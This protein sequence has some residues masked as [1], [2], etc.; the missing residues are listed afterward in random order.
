MRQIFTFKSA[1]QAPVDVGDGQFWKKKQT[2]KLCLF[3]IRTGYFSPG[4]TAGSPYI[5]TVNTEFPHILSPVLKLK[6][7]FLREWF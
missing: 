3:K 1:T 2:P 5:W 4:D 6:K 7:V